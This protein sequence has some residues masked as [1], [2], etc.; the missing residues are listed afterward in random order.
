M[1]V[2]WHGD[3]V[4]VHGALPPSA[5]RTMADCEGVR[6]E[7]YDVS[8]ERAAWRLT[9]RIDLRPIAGFLASLALHMVVGAAALVAIAS[10][11]PDESKV[12]PEKP[13]E[14]GAAASAPIMQIAAN[15]EAT[16]HPKDEHP[17]SVVDEEAPPELPLEESTAADVSAHGAAGTD[18][19]S[20]SPTVCT[21]PKAGVAHGPKCRRTVTITSLSTRPGCFVDTVGKEGQKGTIT[22]PC[23][24]DGPATLT[25]G[26]HSFSGAAAA[27]KI[28]VCTGTEYPFSDGCK[29]TSAQRVSGSIAQGTLSFTYGEAPKPGQGSCAT[30]C[31]AQGTVQIEGESWR[32]TVK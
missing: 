32:H 31:E 15:Q 3:I 9:P 28:D 14:Q 11:S 29:W 19:V 2:R 22:Y 20:T 1:L 12:E 30:A 24:G 27:G 4:A 8:A 16:E 23:D 7:V 26:K 25:F 6:V 13:N 18:A 10:A 5:V 21:P 17:P